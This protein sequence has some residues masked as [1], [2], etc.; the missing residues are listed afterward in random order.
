MQKHTV[1]LP[2][3]QDDTALIDESN[4]T[5]KQGE[6]IVT[7]GY[8]LGRSNARVFDRFHKWKE[9]PPAK[10]KARESIIEWQN[11]PARSRQSRRNHQEGARFAERPPD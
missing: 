4:V 2:T 1:V 8:L 9:I 11:F 10:K 6:S 3:D 5:D 7:R